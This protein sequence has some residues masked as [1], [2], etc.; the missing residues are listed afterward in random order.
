MESRENEFDVSKMAITC[1]Q[2]LP[3]RCADIMLARDTH[4]PIERAIF[5][6]G[7][8]FVEIEQTAVGE[9]NMRLIDYV[10]I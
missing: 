8:A 6:I 5:G 1:F 4:A 2:V 7:A 10:L 3:T 9:F